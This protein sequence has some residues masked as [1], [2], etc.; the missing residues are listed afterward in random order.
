MNIIRYLLKCH[1]WPSRL[2]RDFMS[3]NPA[4]QARVRAVA[5]AII[6]EIDREDDA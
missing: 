5:D 3:S 2:Q 1:R 4:R 6:A